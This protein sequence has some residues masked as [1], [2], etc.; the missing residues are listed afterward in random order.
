MGA[1]LCS[2][3]SRFGDRRRGLQ[4]HR[5]DT[6]RH[7]ERRE[8]RGTYTQGP[9]D[10]AGP[11]AQLLWGAG[12]LDAAGEEYVNVQLGRTDPACRVGRGEHD[13]VTFPTRPGAAVGD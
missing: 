5:W 9:A 8:N 13:R 2:I 1:I 11:K 10:R 7:V 12:R 4:A 6:P 3:K